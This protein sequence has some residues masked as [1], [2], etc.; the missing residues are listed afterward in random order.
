MTC[1]CGEKNERHNKPPTGASCVSLLKVPWAAPIFPDFQKHM[2]LQ[3]TGRV[4]G[5]KP[6]QPEINITTCTSYVLRAA[7][8][9][10]LSNIIPCS[11]LSP[12]VK[13]YRGRVKRQRC[14]NAVE[15]TCLKGSSEYWHKKRGRQK[16]SWP[17]K[18]VR[19]TVSAQWRHR[20][21][22]IYSTH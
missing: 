6:L 11:C 1:D 10:P 18:Q 9:N 4:N 2:S 16:Q 15:L 19:G 20:E 14:E 8:P 3:M 5:L 22:F 13:N 21:L 12:T 17:I 7:S